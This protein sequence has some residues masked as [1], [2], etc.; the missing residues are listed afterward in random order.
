VDSFLDGT[1]TFHVYSVGARYWPLARMYIEGRVGI[2]HG[3]SSEC[4]LDLVPCTFDGI[5][6]G[7]AMAYE[8]VHRSDVAFDLRAEIVLT[9]GSATDANGAS[10]GHQHTGAVG[11]GIGLTFY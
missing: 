1:S 8:L 11:L 9:T 4:T 10:I 2:G 6:G 3:D 7:G 5:A